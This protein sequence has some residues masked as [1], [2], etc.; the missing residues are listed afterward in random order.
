MQF[1]NAIDVFIALGVFYASLNIP[2]F[3]NKIGTYFGIQSIDENNDGVLQS[4]LS[5]DSVFT[6]INIFHSLAFSLLQ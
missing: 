5:K 2:S 1:S 4:H 6:T 3:F